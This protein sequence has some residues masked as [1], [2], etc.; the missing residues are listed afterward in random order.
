[1]FYDQNP[2]A[3]STAIGA[4]ICDTETGQFSEIDIWTSLTSAVRVGCAST[5]I[6]AT[7]SRWVKSTDCFVPRTAMVAA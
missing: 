4:F 3:N 6:S 7:R 2:G 5:S 1:M